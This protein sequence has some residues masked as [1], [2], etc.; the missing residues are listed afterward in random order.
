MPEVAD[1]LGALLSARQIGVMSGGAFSQFERQFLSRL[2]DKTALFKNLF[3][4]PTCATSFYRYEA[5][6]I[7]VYEE[8]LTAEEKNKILAAFQAVFRDTGFKPEKKIY[9][10]IIEDRGSQITFSALGQQAPYH[11]KSTWDPDA[12]KRLRIS[13]ALSCHI[14]EFEIRIGGTNSIDVTRKGIDKAYG[15]KKIKEILRVPE[16]DMLFIGDALFPGGNDYPAY[17]AGVDCLSVSGP[18]E[19]LHYIEK[20]LE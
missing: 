7:T 15:I 3:L 5:D 13:K 19:T 12:V 11:V 18:H 6:W 20:I 4:F 16:R 17:E 8:P 2:P 9:G 14:P 10:E 1:S